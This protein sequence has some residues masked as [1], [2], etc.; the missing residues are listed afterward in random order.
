MVENVWLRPKQQ[1]LEYILFWLELWKSFV[2][3]K[4]AAF[5]RK[6][7]KEKKERNNESDKGDTK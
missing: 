2:M 5:L 4:R 3:Q 6:E 1:Q 7:I